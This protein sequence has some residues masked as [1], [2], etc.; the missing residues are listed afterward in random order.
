[1]LRASQASG[2][3]P[4]SHSASLRTR[5][6]MSTTTEPAKRAGGGPGED[7]PEHGRAH[8]P[9]DPDRAFEV[10]RFGELGDV[11]GELLDG[12]PLAGAGR[13]AMAAQ[14]DRDHPEIGGEL[15][16]RAEEAA[17]RHQPVQQHERRARRP[18]RDRRFAS[19]PKP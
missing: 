8:R 16:L 2:E 6:V 1:M 12:R 17:M 14:V 7:V 10:E 19:R 11:G 13:G 9:A 3:R 18:R 4:R 5:A 15:G